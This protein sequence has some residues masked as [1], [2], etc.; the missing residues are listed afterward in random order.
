MRGYKVFVQN[1]WDDKWNGPY[2]SSPSSWR[3][4]SNSILSVS[5]LNEKRLSACGQGVNFFTNKKFAIK[6]AKDLFSKYVCVYEV[7]TLPGSKIIVP[8]HRKDHKVRTDKLRLGKRIA[9]YCFHKPIKK[10]RKKD[11]C[12]KHR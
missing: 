7:E 10:V 6:L 9:L 2:Y 1:S 5:S 11:G 12:Q 4:A 8:Y 3:I